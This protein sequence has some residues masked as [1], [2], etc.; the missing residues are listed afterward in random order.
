M[1]PRW[2]VVLTT[3]VHVNVDLR[4]RKWGHQ[5][6]RNALE[7]RAMYAQVLRHWFI[8]LPGVPITI[9]ENS[10]D[11][12]DW[13]VGEARQLNR[14]SD[15]A[16]VRLGGCADECRKSRRNAE[17]GCAE[18]HSIHTAIA[19]SPHY[20]RPKTISVR[21]PSGGITRHA[22]GDGGHVDRPRCTHALTVTGRY[23]IT[24]DMNKARHSGTRRP[25]RRFIHM[26]YPSYAGAPAMRSTLGPRRSKPELAGGQQAPPQLQPSAL[27][28]RL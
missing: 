6:Q 24:D 10:G 26:L 16:L 27:A 21:G 9:V 5:Q 7:R 11:S 22:V 17:I 1:R 8:H 12:L 18:A 25:S 2:C 14:T 3:T 4:E 19:R 28:Q 15:L 13:A 23:A 20:A